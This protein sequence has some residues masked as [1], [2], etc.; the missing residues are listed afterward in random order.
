MDF[1]DHL[2]MFN[3]SIRGLHGRENE[4]EPLLKTIKSRL[5]WTLSERC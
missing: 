1:K 4:K 3:S 5:N 2:Q